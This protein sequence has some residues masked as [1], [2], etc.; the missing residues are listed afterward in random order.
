MGRQIKDNQWE[1]NPNPIKNSAE[2][3]VLNIRVIRDI[4]GQRV[5]FAGSAAKG[6]GR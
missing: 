1:D 2:D 4:G 3:C 6:K 5:W